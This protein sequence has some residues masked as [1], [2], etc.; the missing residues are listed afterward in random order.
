MLWDSKTHHFGDVHIVR[1]S[2]EYHMFTEQMRKE[3]TDSDFANNRVVGHYVS[4]DMFDWEPLPD[5]FG[6]G[7]TGEFDGY[8]IYHMG[9]YV[10]DGTWFMHYTGLDK[11]GAGQQQAIGLATS[12]DGIRWTKHPNNPVLRADPRY[13]EPFIPPEA[14]Y[15]KKDGGRLWFRDPFV[16]RDPKTG[17]FGI[18]VMARDLKEHVDVRGCLSWA[19]SRD[20][21][22][23][24][25]KPPIFSPGRFHTIETPSIYEFNGRHY[26]IFMTHPAWGSPIIAN[27]PY[28]T[29]G[30][31]YA[32]SQNGWEGPYLPPKD[33][34]LIA[35]HGQMR[36]GA[37]KIVDGPNGE[38]YL[39][40]W[41]VATSTGNDTEAKGRKFVPAPRKAT[42]TDDGEIHVMYNDQVDS[43]TSRV[44]IKNEVTATEKERW[45]T[46]GNGVIGKNL[47]NRSTATLPGTHGNFVFS[48]R[49]KFHRGERAG[50][51]L[52]TEGENGL[53]AV[54]D[55]RFGRIEFGSLASDKFVD[56]R[57]WKV[58]DEVD[59]K[60]IAY[61]PSIEVYAD[62]RLMIHQVRYRETKG[63]I[64]YIV[65]RGEAEFGQ[66][67]L[68]AFK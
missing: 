17:E 44:A 11:A 12:K 27:D 35:A 57:K 13:Y 22:H 6:C 68:R 31:F 46:Q 29:A 67:S 59:L 64:G 3:I 53:Y 25:T 50:L 30:D 9:V 8:T 33:E 21:V 1:V 14:T 15:Q 55:R 58:K 52:R 61:D 28:Q 32:V 19:T 38:H 24:Q 62:D 48:A 56:A 63:A 18:I 37:A 34:V 66:P 10:H 60:V 26:V 20:L 41:L 51:I 49:V 47:G 16:I 43:R 40:G 39:Y 23:W 7:K 65:E 36:M 4:K 2:G 5:C 42:F 45:R 54:A